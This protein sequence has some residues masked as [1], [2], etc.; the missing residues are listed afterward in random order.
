V[1]KNS[2]V[3]SEHVFVTHYLSTVYL[4]EGFK[5]HKFGSDYPSSHLVYLTGIH[6]LTLVIGF[7]V[8]KH[9]SV[10]L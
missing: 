9:T 7:S 10:A 1:Q 5:V 8:Q 3:T 6:S 2:V 4:Q